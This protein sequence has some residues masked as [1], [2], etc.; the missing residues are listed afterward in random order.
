MLSAQ[1]VSGMHHRRPPPPPFSIRHSQLIFTIKFQPSRSDPVTTYT[2]Q[3]LILPCATGMTISLVLLA[4]SSY[5]PRC[6]TVVWLRIDQKTCLK[7]IFT[8]GCT[9]HVVSNRLEGDDVVTD[10]DGLASAIA[11]VG[12][13]NV[14]A[15]I[16]TTSCFAP[17]RPDDVKG[18]A[19]ICKEAQIPHVVNHAYG[20]QDSQTNKSL[21]SA[22]KL[23]QLRPAHHSALIVCTLQQPLDESTALF[24][25][26][27][28]TSWF[29][30]LSRHCSA[31]V[32]SFKRV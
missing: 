25:P 21:C 27:T 30:Q 3:L 31:R 17:R 1:S 9:A 29:V 4:L 12:P 32:Y 28:K 10:L 24:L 23:P 18:V 6:K 15:V 7:S 11:Q 26:P 22:G 14:L 5:R 13:D 16:S 19:R 20:L 2:Q 8:A